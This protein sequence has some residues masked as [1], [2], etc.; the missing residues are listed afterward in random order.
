MDKIDIQAIEDE[1]NAQLEAI[2]ADPERLLR[3]DRNGDG[4]VDEDE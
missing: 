1:V 3:Y 2:R 4:I